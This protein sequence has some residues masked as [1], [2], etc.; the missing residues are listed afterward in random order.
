VLVHMPLGDHS[1]GVPADT[2]RAR[3]SAVLSA[4]AAIVTTSEWGRNRLMA[5]YGLPAER[6]HVAE[7]GVDAADA[8][9]GSDAGGAMLCVASVIPDKGHG[10]LLDALQM[11]S[12][13]AWQCVC[14]GRLDRAPAFVQRLR[15]RS[16]DAGL[17]DRVHFLG[18]QAGPDLDRSYVSAD[19]LV[20]ASR[21]ET[22]GMAITEALAHA[23]PVVV[24]EVGGVT[25]AVGYGFDGSRPGLLVAPDDP[26]A[27]AAALRAW[28]TDNE[29]RRRL[30]RAA[31]ERRQS[32]HGWSDT[33][34]ILADVLAGAAR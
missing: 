29:L 27:L 25:E 2:I 22:Y 18:P 10:V 7:P 3:E 20:L 21:A 13:L 8:A 19:L 31:R 9:T 30:R 26:T 16:H 34:A 32:L 6:L 4:A 11:V 12:D 5:L 28:L 23:V 33:A 14:V 15:R 24:T 1:V 17:D